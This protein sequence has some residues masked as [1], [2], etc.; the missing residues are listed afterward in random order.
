MPAK[1]PPVAAV[2]AE[3]LSA[4]GQQIRAYRKALRIDATAAAEA[5]GLSR[6]TLHRI[7]RGEPSVAMG[8]YLNALVTLG[9]D[10]GIVA[11]ALADSAHADDRKGWIPV[12]IRIAD[13]PQLK[14]LAWQLHGAA[15][16]TPNEALGIYERNQRHL[17]LKAMQP[18]ER[19]L[20]EALRVAL[21]KSGNV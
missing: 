6:M 7:E 20:L 9:L 5:A 17:D 8:A 3:K 4:L 18:H 21:G 16:L 14:Q 12:R 13:Y 10:F 19:E 15:E 2:A 1:T 11:P